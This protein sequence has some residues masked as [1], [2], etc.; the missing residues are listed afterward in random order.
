MK[1]VKIKKYDDY[2]RFSFSIDTENGK[3]LE[4][5]TQCH[6]GI[7]K[8]KIGKI[9][10]LHI[11]DIEYETEFK[12]FGEY[13]DYRK[14]QEFYKNLYGIEQHTKL[15]KKIEDTCQEAIHEKYPKE[16]NNLTMEDKKE[17]LIELIGYDKKTKSWNESDKKTLNLKEIKMGEDKKVYFTSNYWVR[18]IFK[19]IEGQDKCITNFLWDDRKTTGIEIHDVLNLIENN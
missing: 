17:M 2:V 13:T 16:F 10:F 19:S 9:S 7:T 1:V 5:K 6:G 11:E 18:W 4:F 8:N 14:F 15:I 3:G 12:V